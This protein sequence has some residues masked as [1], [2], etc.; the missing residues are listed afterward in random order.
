MERNCSLRN[1]QD[2][3]SDGKTPF[4][5]RYGEPPC[6]SISPS[7]LMIECH[8]M[9]AKDQ[10]RLHQFWRKILPEIFIGYALHAEVNW[11]GDILIADIE[12]LKILDA[13]EI[14]ELSTERKLSCQRLEKHSESRAQMVQSSWQERIKNYEHQF[15]IGI[16][17]VSEKNI[18]MIFKEKRRNLIKHNSNQRITLRLEMT[19]GVFLGA[20]FIVITFNQEL[21]SMFLRKGYS[22]FPSSIL[23]LSGGPFRHWKC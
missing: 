18:T 19:F 6:E 15:Q 21:R 12:E 23:I 3:S 11:K 22:Q 1:A 9:S 14:L 4:E 17:P 13:S 16:F 10:T 20:A 8:S 5:R 7:G 2:F